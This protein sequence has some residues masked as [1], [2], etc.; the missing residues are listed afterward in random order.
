M[1]SNGCIDDGTMTTIYRWHDWD[2]D[3]CVT[4][5]QRA[6]NISVIMDLKVSFSKR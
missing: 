1:E 4:I 6:K 3:G 5:I 2:D